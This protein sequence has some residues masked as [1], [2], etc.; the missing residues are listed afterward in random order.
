MLGPN[1]PQKWPQKGWGQKCYTQP[2]RIT[3]AYNQVS[4]WKTSY[5]TTFFCAATTQ[6]W[7]SL[8]LLLKGTQKG[9]HSF[10][11]L[12]REQLRKS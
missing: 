1:N 3:E 11:V 10:S 7:R 5:L 9:G 4:A 2:K 12:N 8:E 6:A